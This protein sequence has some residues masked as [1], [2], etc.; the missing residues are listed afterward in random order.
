MENLSHPSVTV[1]GADKV[2]IFDDDSNFGTLLTTK[3]RAAGFEPSY[4][5]SLVDMGSFARIKNYDLAIVDFYMDTI[6]G[7]EI[8]EYVDTFFKDIP[9]IIVSGEDFSQSEKMK[10]WPDTVRAFVPKT[11]GID[12]IL[13]T[14]KA[15][16]QRER[17]LKRLAKRPGSGV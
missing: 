1:S 11:D 4:F 15:V 13:T 7:D 10:Q 12:R 9:V 5:T 17:M 2:V 3:A 8:A 14:A 16:L 6:R